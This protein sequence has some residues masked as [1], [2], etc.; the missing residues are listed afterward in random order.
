M[1]NLIVNDTT[2][3][4]D[5]E[6]TEAIAD[7]FESVH[8]IDNNNMFE[9]TNITERSCEVRRN[10]D[11][12]PKHK[13]MEHLTTPSE[14]AEYLPVLPTRPKTPGLDGIPYTLLRN[15]SRKVVVELTYIANAMFK[16]AHFPSSW[17]EATIVPIPNPKKYHETPKS[18]HPIS[19]QCT[20]LSSGRA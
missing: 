19:L 15:L 3:T 13:I 2:L 14:V 12:I 11:H 9:Q 20:S 17:K 10:N 6:M 5:A 7:V 1:P 18:C 8:D 4:T 16:L